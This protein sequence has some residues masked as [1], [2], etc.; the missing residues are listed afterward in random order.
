MANVSFAQGLSTNFQ[1][2]V[3]DPNT[4]YFLTDTHEI[5]LGDAKYSTGEEISVVISGQ[6]DV[7]SD[8]SF[9]ANTKVLTFI[10]GYASDTPSIQSA[11]ASCVKTLRTDSGSSIVVDDSD[12]ENIKLSLKLAEGQ[13]SG[14]VV[15]EETSQG[16][17]AS[18]DVPPTGLVGIADGDKVL[19]ETDGIVSSSLSISTAKQN[20]ITYVILKGIGGQ[21][22]SKFDASAFVKD[23]MLDSVFLK[24]SDDGQHRRILVMRFNTDAGKQDIELDVSEL[25][26]TYRPKADGG[27]GLSSQNEFYIDNSVAPATEPINHDIAPQFGETVTLNAVK[28]NSHGL[29]TGTGTFNVTIPSLFGGEVGDDEHLITSLR[30]SGEGSVTGSTVEI[31]DDINTRAVSDGTHQIP[32]VKAVR[33]AIQYSQ[34]VWN[35]V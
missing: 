14:N 9:N 11:L 35:I 25:A 6:G 31:I 4:L 33:N 34:V 32:T 30:V 21:E 22:I 18:I 24:W 1:P 27:L 16:L 12:S 15:L 28:Y 17:R 19:S 29:V 10:L 5:Y 3:K 8:A 7:V 20:D 2:L 13:Y 26:T 23:G